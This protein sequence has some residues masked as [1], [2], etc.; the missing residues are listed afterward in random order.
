MRY[1]LRYGASIGFA[2]IVVLLFLLTSAGTTS[3]KLEP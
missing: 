2:I 3:Q 1:R